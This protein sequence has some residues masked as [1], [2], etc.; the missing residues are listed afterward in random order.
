MSYQATNWA[1]GLELKAP[2]KPVL[3]ALADMADEAHTCFPSQA[4]LAHMTG[5]DQRTVRRAIA[6][7]EAVELIRRE[8]RHDGRGY[9]TSDRFVLAFEA[10]LADTLPTGHRAHRADSP[11]LAD[12]QS[13]PSG[14][15]DLVTIR[16]P[17]EN[18]QQAGAKTKRTDRPVAHRHEPNTRAA[19]ETLQA[20]RGL[21]LTVDE[22][23]R[24]AYT[25]GGGDPWEG[26]RFGIKPQTEHSLAGADD[27]AA[28]LRS[29]LKKAQRSAA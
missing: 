1:Y 4:R 15:S 13:G 3:V 18:H 11:D 7:L 28:V 21:P 17:S 24:W 22:L 20:E 27:P 14:H 23:V 9:R 6:Q 12:T 5:F 10:R 26:Y 16:E 19:L 2:A 25:L 8:R 29:R